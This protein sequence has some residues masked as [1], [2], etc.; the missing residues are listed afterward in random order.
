MKVE[1]T[2]IRHGESKVQPGGTLNYNGYKDWTDAYSNSSIK[3]LKVYP[4]DTLEKVNN[5]KII[6]T[7]TLRRSIDSAKLLNPK[8]ELVKRSLF[9]EIAPPLHDSIDHSHVELS[10]VFWTVIESSISFFS[11]KHSFLDDAHI[12]ASKAAD[13]L[14]HFA[15]E[16]GKA[17]LVG[18]GIFN[19]FI[20]ETLVNRGWSEIKK[21]EGHYWSCS[22][23]QK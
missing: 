10:P 2:L 12:R 18:H 19:L 16:H 9:N 1:I 8:A 3:P 17:V 21:P 20:G 15:K 5:T 11:S 13:W 4:K 7:S 22:V 14:I 23:Y 6:I